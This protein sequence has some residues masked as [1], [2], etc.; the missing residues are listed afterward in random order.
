M[1]K[2]EIKFGFVL[3]WVIGLF[4]GFSIS[5]IITILIKGVECLA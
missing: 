5:I 1:N 3:T 2:E 4:M